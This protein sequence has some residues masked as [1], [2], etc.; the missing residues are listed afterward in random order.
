MI[1]HSSHHQV[2]R[3]GRESVCG[4][5]ETG[6]AVADYYANV[7]RLDTLAVAFSPIKLR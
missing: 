7:E 5:S 3:S 1:I 6:L 4:R 2:A